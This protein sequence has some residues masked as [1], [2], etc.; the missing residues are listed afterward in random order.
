[1]S[2]T[3]AE[4]AGRA[5]RH[6]AVQTAESKNGIPSRCI[7]PATVRNGHKAVPVYSS[8][9][10]F[11][12]VFRWITSQIRRLLEVGNRL[13]HG[14]REQR[15]GGAERLQAVAPAAVGVGQ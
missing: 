11:Q 14:A 7:D 5:S 15:A 1:M 9:T 12:G 10:E 6:S 8:G 2:S 4:D 13:L 3:V